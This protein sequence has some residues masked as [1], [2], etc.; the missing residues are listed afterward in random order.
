VIYFPIS[1]VNCKRGV[2][3][4]IKN[5]FAKI[6]MAYNK[7]HLLALPE[8]LTKIFSYLAIDK[9]LY[10]TLFVN[11]LWYVPPQYY[12]NESNSLAMVTKKFLATGGN[13]KK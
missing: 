13:S 8:L 5:K 1:K 12:G 7:L 9:S 4:R 3:Y 6:T 10:P 11:R 2:I